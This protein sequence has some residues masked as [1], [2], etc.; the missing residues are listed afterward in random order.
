MEV[1]SLHELEDM[2]KTRPSFE[3]CRMGFRTSS[4]SR[5]YIY[6]VVTI[7]GKVFNIGVWEEWEG[8]VGSTGGQGI[9]KGSSWISDSV[10]YE[11]LPE[12]VTTWIADSLEKEWK[13]EEG[14]E[15][16]GGGSRENVER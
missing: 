8:L 4:V 13:S 12:N 6:L 9:E 10:S 14:E 3:F 15:D 1:G 11:A 5:V 16:G 2:S 7:D